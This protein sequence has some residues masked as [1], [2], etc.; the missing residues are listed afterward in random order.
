MVVSI[1]SRKSLTQDAS[2]LHR[3]ILFYPR[4]YPLVDYLVIP[5]T[6]RNFVTLLATLH[7]EDVLHAC[8]VPV[9]RHPILQMLAAVPVEEIQVFVN[10]LLVV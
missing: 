5:R 8:N 9:S 1:R 10:V 4:V 7:K 2:P 6:R 3:S